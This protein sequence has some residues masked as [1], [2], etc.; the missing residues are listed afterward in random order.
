MRYLTG[1][2]ESI[3]FSEDCGKSPLNNRN[4]PSPK[5]LSNTPRT[6]SQMPILDFYVLREFLVPFTAL[7]F[8]FCLL[9]LVGDMFNDLNEFL[10]H[11]SPVSLAARYFI[12]KM[13][14][15]IRFILPITVLLSC[16][17]TLANF[18][19]HREI[20]AMRASGISLFRSAFPI[21]M[22]AFAVTLVNFW[23]N[24]KVVPDC[25]RE[26]TILIET[27]QNPDYE[28]WMHSM[29][30]YRSSDKKRD[31]LFQEFDAEG[32]QK[33]IILKIYVDGTGESEGRQVLSQD[34]RAE[35]ARFIEGKGWEFKGVLRTP[36][37]QFYLPGQPE[38]L[39]KL[40]ISR[41][42]I[43]ETP[44]NI[45]NSIKPPEE[46][47]TW[48]IY[49]ILQSSK[50]MA[51]TLRNIYTTIFYYRLAFPWVCF[52]CVFL[53]LP[54]AAKNERSGIFTAITAAVG[55]IV[56]YQVMTEVFML[57]GKQG[58]LPPIVGGLAPTVA[59]ALY[60]WFFLIRKA[61]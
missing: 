7:L 27:V 36:Y 24:E 54:L 15:N 55:I 20:T 37:S 60:G 41:D 33:N 22:V 42:E 8:A 10:D 3:L 32:V 47:P 23:F 57:L 1:K 16:M 38:E 17:Y 58:V 39:E 35:E 29:L 2:R 46:L 21:Y 11:K 45:I 40:T 48:I 56:L 30:Q 13:P 51:P 53:A 9:F 4:S 31:W 61:G 43:P 44:D 50:N 14:G 49:D 18:G 26:S 6:F 28:K 52:L 59:F 5:Y 12:L 25:E 34:I 19:R